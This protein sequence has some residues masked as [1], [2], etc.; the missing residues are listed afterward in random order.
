MTLVGDVELLLAY[1][2]SG[3]EA[4]LQQLGLALL[5][6]KLLGRLAAQLDTVLLSLLVLM[7]QLSRASAPASSAAA[8]C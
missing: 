2:A 7:Q 3:G 8:A 6:H 1:Q 4:R 5:L